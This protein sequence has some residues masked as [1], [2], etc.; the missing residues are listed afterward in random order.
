MKNKIKLMMEN[1]DARFNAK[2]YDIYKEEIVEKGNDE[3]F[4]HKNKIYFG[5]RFGIFLYSAQNVWY[6]KKLS[7]NQ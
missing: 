7:N 4:I 1:I 5:N 6:Q 2:R 3:Y